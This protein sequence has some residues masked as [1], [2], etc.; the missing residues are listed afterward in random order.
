M[1]DEKITTKKKLENKQDVI[2]DKEMSFLDHLEELRWTIIKS[3]V[4]VL[5]FALFAFIIKSFIFDFLILAPKEPDFFTNVMFCELG[6]LIGSDDLCINTEYFQIIN[7]QMSGQFATHIKVSMVV[8]LIL[9]FPYVFWQFWKF[10]SPALYSTEKT[11]SRSATFWTSILFIFGVLFGYFIITPLTLHFFSGYFVSDVVSNQINLNSY[12]SIITSVVVS[13]GVIFEM[14]MLIY[15]LSKAGIVDPAF[16]KKYR[17]HSL[18]I[19]LI[20]AAFITPPDILSQVIVSIPLI[21]LYEI[22][23]II[24]KRVTRKNKILAKQ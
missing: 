15:F 2:N 9:A 10:I 7:I 11:H 22:G 12:I 1:S 3:F 16:L 6:K 13:S 18:V 19:I 24:S 21:I 5:I 8:G 20:V 17:K 23:I 4:A 14:P